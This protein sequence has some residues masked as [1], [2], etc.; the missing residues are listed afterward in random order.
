MAKRRAAKLRESDLYAP[1]RDHL[2][3]LGYRV[4]GEVDGCDVTA[5]R[6]DDL[7]VVELKR[8]FGI[9]LLLQATQRQR[10]ADS[11]YVAVPRPRSLGRR[12][13]WPQIQQ[14]LRRLELGLLFVSPGSRSARVECVFHPLPH[15]KRRD[16]RRRR[17]VLTEIAGRSGDHNEGGSVRRKLVTAYRECAI[18]IACCLEEHGPLAPRQ[19]RALGTGAKTLAILYDDVYG[20]FERV[21]RALYALRPAARAELAQYPALLREYRARARAEAPSLRI[22]EAS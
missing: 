13:A 20:W 6:G 9:E 22:E 3:A 11:V 1:V 16:A 15:A 10:I 4:R 21:G 8:R 14:L 7:V 19:L 12:S 5:T 17:A 18:H 2:A